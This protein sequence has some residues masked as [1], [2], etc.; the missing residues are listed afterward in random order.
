MTQS[1]KQ[2][3]PAQCIDLVFAHPCSF[4]TDS[5]M[6]MNFAWGQTQ[7]A[8]IGDIEELAGQPGDRALCLLLD[9]LNC[10]RLF[11]LASRH[12]VPLVLPRLDLRFLVEP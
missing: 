6:T 9:P 7:Q 3:V 12:C 4:P 1:P 8:S 2:V 5:V 10:C 11:H